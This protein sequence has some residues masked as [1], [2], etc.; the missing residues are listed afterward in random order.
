MIILNGIE[1]STALI[2]DPSNQFRELEHS[3]FVKEVNNDLVRVLSPHIRRET[4]FRRMLIEDSYRLAALIYI[5][6]LPKMLENGKMSCETVLQQ[7]QPK[8]VDSSTDWGHTI[9]MILRHLTG[10]VKVESQEN[11]YYVLQLMD[12]SLPLDWSAWKFVRD[13]LL[14]FLLHAEVCS[15][16]HQ[17][18]WLCRM[19][20]G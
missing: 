12:F 15:G 10:R 18:L 3:R 6:T 13:L 17:D 2:L 7:L 4:P 5:S 11:I 20:N 9:E 8:L 16:V 1:T 19:K 14:D